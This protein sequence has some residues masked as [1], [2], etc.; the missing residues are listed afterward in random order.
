MLRETSELSDLVGI[1]TDE[2]TLLT[3]DGNRSG[4]I[5]GVPASGV[6]SDLPFFYRKRLPRQGCLV[7]IPSII[8][9][10]Q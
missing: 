10:P 6:F 3:L 7:A 4:D 9:I 2:F 8:S 5:E 1:S